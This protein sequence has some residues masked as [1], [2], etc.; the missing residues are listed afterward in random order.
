M[1]S[2]ANQRRGLRLERGV[3]VILSFGLDKNSNVSG[4]PRPLIVTSCDASLAATEINLLDV[5]AAGRVSALTVS[6]TPVYGGRVGPE[7]SSVR[8]NSGR[9]R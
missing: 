7:D 3:G 8:L 9:A 5:Q 4:S 1:H 6:D 2:A